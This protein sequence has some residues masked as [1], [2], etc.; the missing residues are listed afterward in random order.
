MSTPALTSL[1]AYKAWATDEL[2]QELSKISADQHPNALHSAIRT[3]NHVHVVD[4]IFRAHLL[5]E[6]HAYRMT[7][8]ADTP[9]L[10]A[11]RASAAATDNW[12]AQYVAA[13][14]PQQ[15][16]ETVC[17]TFTDGNTGSMSREEMLLHVISHGVYHRGTLA[18]ILN[19][20]S[21]APPRD[22]LTRYLH[23]AEPIRRELI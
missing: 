20:V 6:P 14:T 23:T 1:F 3:M 19:A 22:L 12:Y 10:S 9:T 18:H 13:A 15:L 11:L 5:G 8:T 21:I 16:C 17:F 4:R 2:F 7:N